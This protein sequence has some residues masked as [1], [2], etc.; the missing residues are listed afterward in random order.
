MVASVEVLP[1]SFFFFLSGLV[2]LIFGGLVD[3]TFGRLVGLVF[4]DFSDP[5]DDSCGLVGLVI[6]LL[7]ELDFFEE[8]GFF[9]VAVVVV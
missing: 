1:R 4:F 6:S 7:V 5:F 9:V 2:D 8:V 3:L